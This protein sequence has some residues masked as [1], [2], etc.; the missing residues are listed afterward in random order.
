MNV[1]PQQAVRSGP[2]RAAAGVVG[3]GAVVTGL[4][5]AGAPWWV[6]AITGGVSV[7]AA[8]VIGLAQILMPQDSEHKRDLWLEVLRHRERHSSGGPP[9]RGASRTAR[10]RR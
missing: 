4:V 3:G 10:T 8:V 5:M 9:L 2:I 7:A 6:V 1:V